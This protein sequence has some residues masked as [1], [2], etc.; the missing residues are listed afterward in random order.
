MN[1]WWWLSFADEE[2]LGACLVQG[3]SFILAVGESLRI[4]IN[5]GGQVV[6]IG[7]ISEEEARD[8]GTPLNTLLRKED[9]LNPV[10]FDGSD[11]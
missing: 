10:H 8:G 7:P 9:I 6:G 4:G 1:N 3:D 5:P 2:F 11:A